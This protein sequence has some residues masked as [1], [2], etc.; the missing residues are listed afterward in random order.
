MDK[1]LSLPRV[2]LDD[3]HQALLL[4]ASEAGRNGVHFKGLIT[5]SDA[6]P[7]RR[8]STARPFDPFLNATSVRGGPDGVAF[9]SDDGA[10]G[11]LD[12]ALLLPFG[13][14]T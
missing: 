1:L 7:G 4:D 3:T 13:I 11:S 12:D 2:V 6:W 8:E 14:T 5:L 10:L 9:F